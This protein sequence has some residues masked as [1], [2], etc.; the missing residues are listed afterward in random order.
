MKKRLAPSLMNWARAMSPLPSVR[1]ISQSALIMTADGGLVEANGAATRFARALLSG[2]LPDAR[3]AICRAARDG[4]GVS[5][6]A[7]IEAE[8]SAVNCD[9]DAIPLGQ[10]RALVM[11]RHGALESNLR[12]ALVDSRRRYKDLV[13]VSSDFAWE[14]GADGTFVFVSPG[15]ALGWQADE[16]L[17][18]TPEAFVSAAVVDDDDEAA[19]APG[20]PFRARRATTDAEVWFRRADK[21]LACLSASVRPLYDDQGEWIGARGICRDVS[22]HRERDSLLARAHARERLFGYIVRTMRDEVEPANMLAAAANAVARAVTARG[23]E[24]YRIGP[25]GVRR[26][27]GFGPEAPQASSGCIGAS[28]NRPGP[29]AVTGDGMSA[30]AVATRY[31]GAPNGVLFLWRDGDLGPF[32]DDE[33]EIVVEAAEHLAIAIEQIGAHERLQELSATDAMTGLLNRRSFLAGLARRFERVAQ[34]GRH[35]ALMYCDLDNFKQ[36]ND[37]HGHERGDAAICKA[38]A[39]LR[40]ATRGED[41]VARLGGDEFALWLEGADADATRLRADDLLT[42]AQ[43]LA[44]FSGSPDAS[45]GMSLGAALVEPGAGESLEQLMARADAAMYASKKRGK[46]QCTIAQPP[47]DRRRRAGG[48]A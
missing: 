29:V 45:L 25:D 17:G 9:F 10:R 41:L 20:N 37:T 19:T 30:M 39:I 6:R 4:V 21:T 28:L 27:A 8:G 3:Q 2:A 42:R 46:G 16:L 24:I 43:E 7:V 14:V 34:G 18:R 15:G 31:Q 26:A 22:E 47:E 13:E 12:E 36:V 33:R 1:D 48:H 44:A 40:G 23:T 38:A 32:A 11:A 5:G 35:G